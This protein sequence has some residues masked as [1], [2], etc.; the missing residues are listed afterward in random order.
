MKKILYILPI[1]ALLPCAVS[2]QTST[3]NYVMT[4]TL[5]NASGTS[6]KA[7]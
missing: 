1:L 4:E 6:M 5:L 2:A 7:V 3:E